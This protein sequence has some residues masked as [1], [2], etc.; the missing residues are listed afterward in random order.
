[1]LIIARYGGEEFLLCFDS[2]QKDTVIKT[3]EEIRK[4][5][6]LLNYQHEDHQFSTTVSMGIVNAHDESLHKTLISRADKCLYDAKHNGKD[7]IIY[8]D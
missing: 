7:Q 3:C 5:V 1:M 4:S 2:T 8:S 6:K